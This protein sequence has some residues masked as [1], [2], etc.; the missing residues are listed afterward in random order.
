[1]NPQAAVEKWLRDG[2]VISVQI[3]FRL[4]GSTELR[5]IVARLRKYMPID[6]CW[7]THKQ[8][9]FKVY[10]LGISPDCYKAARR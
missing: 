4:F 5:V 3:C 6:D 9:R 7:V 2:K 1:M 10:R 8:K